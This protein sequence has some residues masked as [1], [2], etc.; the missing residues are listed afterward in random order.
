MKQKV[1]P[2]VISLKIF[3][4]VELK[5]LLIVSIEMLPFLLSL[6]YEISLLHD[7]SLGGVGQGRTVSLGRNSVLEKGKRFFF[8]FFLR[9][10]RCHYQY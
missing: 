3:G 5:H 9:I 4:R 1:H 7:Y 10:M 8:F 2:G 6:Q